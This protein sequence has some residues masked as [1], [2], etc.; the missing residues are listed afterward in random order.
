MESLPVLWFREAEPDVGR[1]TRG[2]CEAQIQH[3]PVDLH[4]AL[5]GSAP[6]EVSG[7]GASRLSQ[8]GA[9]ERISQ[10]VR[11][12][13]GEPGGVPP[14]HEP[15]QLTIREIRLGSSGRVATTGRPCAKSV[16]RVPLLRV[17]PSLNG[18]TPT[19]EP[20]SNRDASSPG[21]YPVI[22]TEPSSPTSPT[23]APSLFQYQPASSP[24][25]RLSTPPTSSRRT[26]GLCSSTPRYAFS[27]T[28]IPLTGWRKPK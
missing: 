5:R 15:Q 2:G 17:T 4:V 20:E 16:W 25:A 26:C 23:S 9:R 21:T 27:S 22:P 12:R 1:S 24:R 3:R 28:S 8:T 14:L 6:G 19:S 13:G 11:E 10:Q 18:S 7:V